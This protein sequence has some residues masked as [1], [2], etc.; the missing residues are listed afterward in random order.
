MKAFLPL[1]LLAALP[2]A[3]AAPA[4]CPD[5]GEQLSEYLASAKQ[6][7]GFDGEVRVEFE[8]GADGRP[9]VVE[10]DGSRQYRSPL[11]IAVQT[12]DCQAGTP[13]RY[14]LNIRFAEPVPSSVAAAA[15][16]TVAQASSP[17]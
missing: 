13:Q 2:T 8:V 4:A 12:L 17:R 6:R 1:L 15:S 14:V 11:R 5:A 3:F 10:L 16:A 7:I 9:R